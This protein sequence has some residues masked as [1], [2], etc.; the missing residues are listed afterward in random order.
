MPDAL[1]VMFYSIGFYLFLKFIDEEK[2]IHLITFVLFTTLAGLVKPL[3]LN[4]GIIQ[5]FILL[6]GKKETLRNI[7]LWFGWLT[8]VL[9]V[10]SYMYFSY[11]L[12]LTFGNTFG[13]IGGEKKFPTL[14]GLTV[15]IHYPKLFLYVCSL[16]IRGYRLVLFNLSDN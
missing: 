5:F 7:K 15:L 12:Y 3:A 16:G 1:S 14:K 2:N 13:V 4:L 6:L 10:G 9:I 8:V 11:N